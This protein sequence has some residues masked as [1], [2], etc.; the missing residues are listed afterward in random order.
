VSSQSRLLSSVASNYEI[1]TRRLTAK[2][3]DIPAWLNPGDTIGLLKEA[4]ELVYRWPAAEQE[5][6]RNGK[7]VD[8]ETLVADM[9]KKNS[10]LT[11]KTQELPTVNGILAMSMSDIL[12]V[13]D[14]K[15]QGKWRNQG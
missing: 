10:R 15:R 7:L 3:E 5:V 12:D 9:F 14:L 2:N 6:L 4:F 8:N 1:L 13:H 11:L